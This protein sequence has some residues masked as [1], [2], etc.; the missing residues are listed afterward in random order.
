MGLALAETTPGPLI[1]VLQYVGFMGSYRFPGSLDPMLS[2]FIG[3]CLTTWIALYSLLFFLFFA[4]A[5]YIEFIRGKK[6]F[7]D[8]LSAITAA[9][10][11]VILNL[12]IWFI[13]NALF[14]DKKTFTRFYF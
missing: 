3:S 10:V 5:P 7:T 9:V 6:I 1:Q 8:V 11:G 14:L 12:S 2:A 4:F 13:F